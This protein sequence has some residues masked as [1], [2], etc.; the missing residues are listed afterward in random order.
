MTKA[1]E[2]VQA[3]E[4]TAV[5]TAG[6]T[7]PAVM[8][9]ANY[10]ALAIQ[11]KQ[12]GFLAANEGLDLDYVRMGQYLK[13]SKKG[14][15][16]EAR[17]ELVSYGDTI[18]VVVAKAEKR[19]TLWGLE[20]SPEDGVLIVSD[21]VE[22]DAIAALESWLSQNPERAADYSIKDIQLRLTTF[23][24]PV[25][26][27]G[28]VMLGPD[29]APT[30]YLMSFAQG[31]TFGFGNYAMGIFDGKSK[32]IGVPANTGANKVVTRMV[33]EERTRAGSKDSYLGLKFECLGMFNPADYG[34]TV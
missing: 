10:I 12:E 19:Y 1:K 5:Q 8:S 17:D 25:H 9:N 26:A 6:T 22:A 23:I 28:Q 3:T 30:I 24:V 16:V 21:P 15:F 2:A 31:D 13:I 11:A 32:S 34:I 7:A 33:T 4:E 18:D 20:E 27:N 14:N 29:Q